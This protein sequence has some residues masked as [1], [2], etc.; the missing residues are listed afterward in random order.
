MVMKEVYVRNYKDFCHAPPIF[1]L[2]ATTFCGK[3]KV[4]S[5]QRKWILACKWILAEGIVNK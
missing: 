1:K 5:K 2:E 4:W 3:K